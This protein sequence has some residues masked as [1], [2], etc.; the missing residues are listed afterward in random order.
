MH[1][2][3]PGF[4][5]S[6]FWFGGF[7]GFKCLKVSWLLVRAEVPFL[8]PHTRLI[9]FLMRCFVIKE[10]NIKCLYRET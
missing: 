3:T 9:S 4:S 7:F 1:Q 2:S 8:V 5:F 6:S 10:A